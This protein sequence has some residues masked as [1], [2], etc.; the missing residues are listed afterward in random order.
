MKHKRKNHLLNSND[1]SLGDV[2]EWWITKYPKDIFVKS[3]LLIIEIRERMEKILYSLS[4]FQEPII[5]F[6][7][8]ESKRGMTLREVCRAYPDQVADFLEQAFIKHEIVKNIQKP[9]A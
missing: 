8:L 5:D 2:A 3:P 9:E 1:F 6:Y 7:F 4:K